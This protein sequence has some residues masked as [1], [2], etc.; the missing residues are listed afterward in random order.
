MADI[1][2]RV[3]RESTGCAHDDCMRIIPAGD[4]VMYRPIEGTAVCEPLCSVH[5]HE[6]LEDEKLTVRLSMHRDSQVV[7]SERMLRV[8]SDEDCDACNGLGLIFVH[9][10]EDDTVRSVSCSSCTPSSSRPRNIDDGTAKAS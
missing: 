1:I 2:L 3:A 5:G 8:T 9:G 6:A 10:D 4:V 7:Q